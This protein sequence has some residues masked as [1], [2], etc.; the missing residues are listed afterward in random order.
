MSK[1]SIVMYHYVRDLKNSRYPNIKGLDIKLFKDQIEYFNNEFNVITMEDMLLAIYNK[2]NLPKNSLLLTF[3]DGYLDNY[4]NVL[5]IL[6]E[7]NMQGSFFISSKTFVENKVLDVNK[8]HFIL[9]SKDEKLI[10]EDIFKLLNY[11]R[12]ENFKIPENKVLYDKLTNRTSRYDNKEVVFIKQLLQN[13]LE[14]S[15]RNII[16]DK[17]FKSIVGVN[18]EAFA[19]ELYMNY[20]QIKFMKKS[21][22]YIGIHGYSHEWLG[23]LKKE[24]MIN[25]IN[26]GME[27]LDE[28]IDKNTLVIN[29]PYGSYNDDV[30]EHSKKIGCKAG[31]STE[32]NI[33]DIETVNPFIIPRF[34]TNDFPPKSNNFKKYI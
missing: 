16:A 5:P 2:A 25:D 9:A 1:V 21:G 19:K 20:D 3:D 8:I 12:G 26:K 15:L 29:Y 14:E 7:Y 18:E 6:K 11:Y 10:C 30:I 13:E 28:V 34:D 31:V 24:S 17:L 32:V 4:T 27:A 33:V 22:M 23:K